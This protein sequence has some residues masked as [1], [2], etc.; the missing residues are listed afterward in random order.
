MINSIDMPL[1]LPVTCHT[2][3][4]GPGTTFV[5]IRGEKQR[6][7]AYI[8]LALKRGATTIVVQDDEDVDIGLLEAYGAK[9]IR[10]LN[11]RK[12][13][14]ELSAAF[15]GY[16]SQH[17]KI[18]AV[19]GTKGKTTTTHLIKHILEES[20]YAVAC[21]SGVQHTIGKKAFTPHL[22]TEQPDYLH[23]FFSLCYNAGIEWVVMEVAAQAVSLHRT[24]G[25]QFSALVFTNF[26]YEHAEFY[27]DQEAYF[28]AKASLLDAICPD[29]WLILNG[30][31]SRV[32]T[33]KKNKT[34][35]YG[36][37]NA[38]FVQG[39]SRTTQKL[40][41]S[42]DMVLPD[43]EMAVSMDGLLGEHN[44]YNVLAATASARVLGISSG[45]IQTSLSTF[46]GVPGRLR[47]YELLGN[48][49]AFIDY[50]SNPASYEAVLGTLRPLTSQLHVIFGA[51]GDRDPLKRPIMGT[52]AARFADWIYL[53]TDNPRSEDPLAIIREIES[54][55][56]YEHKH[57][58]IVEPDRALAIKKAYHSAAQGSILALL[59][60]GAED[61]QM[62][63]NTRIHFSEERIL[64]SFKV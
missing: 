23:A 13:L 37:K 5:A 50:A 41:L 22:T 38:A 62:V 43:G 4:V 45:D 14:A 15:W 60:K 18:L 42:I 57:K 21:L 11:A 34:L 10:V 8:P 46:K 32:S 36:M 2:D 31:D 25:I 52:M 27:A 61:Y 55:I 58:V 51:G 26:S 53:T 47:K 20:G 48:K 6:G 64:E 7:T 1:F 19:T 59:G 12:A 63:G 29:G 49:V 9:L 17:L 56:P 3:H 30:D 16:P 33:L 24:H 35:F 39:T 28:N 44:V 54:G 40:G